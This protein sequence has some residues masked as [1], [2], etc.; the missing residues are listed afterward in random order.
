MTLSDS[1]R[2]TLIRGLFL[3]TCVL[4]CLVTFAWGWVVRSDAYRNAWQES[5]AA[6]LGMRVTVAQVRTP[7][8]GTVLLENVRGY[9]PETDA[10]VFAC[11]TLEIEEYAD[12]RH[13]RASQP[14]I[15]AVH[16]A[17]L[18]AALE[19]RLRRETRAAE[20][21]VTFEAAEL[22]WRV[23]TESQTLVDVDALA[24]K[25]STKATSALP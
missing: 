2:R 1:R 23:G 11:R 7:R 6:Q 16:G 15:D 13:L 21:A 9:D 22:T 25:P 12:G 19:R 8:P 3:C 4:P 17:R 14:E 24:G 5:I 18:F 20:T 10:Q